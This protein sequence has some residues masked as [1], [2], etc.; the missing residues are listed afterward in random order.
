VESIF[1]PAARAMLETR[2][3]ALRA[4]SLRQW[5][6]MTPHQAV[7]HMSD[8][9]RMALRER[10]VG[11][12]ATTFAPVIR[13]VALRLP[14]RWPRGIRTM[15]ECEQGCGGTTPIEFECDRA[16]LVALMARF[17]A[18]SEADRSSTHPIFGRMTTAHWGSFGYRHLDHHLRQF[19]V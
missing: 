1:D 4:D 8:V 16:E 14:M 11:T 9:F 12:R 13:F 2:L 3:R 10:S 15:P 18:S 19:G 5:G 6:R 7:C 17:G